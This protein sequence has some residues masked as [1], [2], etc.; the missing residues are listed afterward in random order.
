MTSGAPHYFRQKKFFR[1]IKQA[2]AAYRVVPC[3]LLA[4]HYL[5]DLGRNHVP[6]GVLN[7]GYKL[8][9]DYLDNSHYEFYFSHYPKRQHVMSLIRAFKDHFDA[10]FEDEFLKE[11]EHKAATES[12]KRKRDKMSTE[13]EDDDCCDSLSSTSDYEEMTDDEADSDYDPSED[14]MDEVDNP[15]QAED[16][17]EMDEDE[18]MEAMLLLEV[19]NNIKYWAEHPLTQN[20]YSEE[21]T[22]FLQE[23]TT[24]LDFVAG[25][26]KEE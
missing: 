7:S 25:V 13:E 21:L 24:A 20:V 22:K 3:E 1:H 16:D 19:D 9:I 8:E 5:E 4:H 15:E 2:P 11:I 17:T 6:G 10:Q 26:E 23:A 18:D 12:H 14:E